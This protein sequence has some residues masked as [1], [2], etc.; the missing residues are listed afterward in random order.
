[1][2]AALAILA[3]AFLAAPA[4]AADFPP[5]TGDVVDD[6]HVLSPSAKQIMTDDLAQLRHTTG[7][8]LVVL[9]VASLNGQPIER[10][11]IALFRAWKVGRKGYDD[12]TVLI[13]APKEHQDRIE[14]GYGLEST[15]TDAQSGAIL[16][17]TIKPY[18]KAGDYDGAALA[19][20]R[21]IAKVI[22]PASASPAKPVPV[23][24][25]PPPPWWVWL[26]FAGFLALLAGAV[27]LVVFAV[28][29]AIRSAIGARKTAAE[30]S[31]R[32]F[33]GSA[34]GAEAARQARATADSARGMAEAMA[35]MTAGMAASQARSQANYD[36]MM[37]KVEE[38]KRRPGTRYTQH[39]T[40]D[41]TPAAGATAEAAPEAAAAAWPEPPVADT[42]QPAW[43]PP[44]API[45]DT[46]PAPAADPAPSSP[47]DDS[48]NYTGGSAGGGGASDNW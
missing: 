26:I 14:V 20:E 10:Y 18:L 6:A 36:A 5:L 45:P 3:A 42:T 15:L 9:T 38:M 41:D 13:I 30:A 39:P 8:R 32:G 48:R 21:A 43:E 34:A 31:S 11:G 27:A 17:D 44:A 46:T 4:L 35:A 12:G 25:L 16:R 24:D 7:H 47:A 33:A 1:M 22:T 23:P 2:K 19:G 28:R 29:A 37:A 40:Q